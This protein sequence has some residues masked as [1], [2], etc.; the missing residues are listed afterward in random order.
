MKEVFLCRFCLKGFVP[1]LIL[2][3][4]SCSAV[5]RHYWVT[6]VFISNVLQ[7]SFVVLLFSL[8]S[9]NYQFWLAVWKS[10]RVQS[11]SSLV[12]CYICFALNK[13][14][15]SK[16]AEKVAECPSWYCY[17]WILIYRVYIWWLFPSWSSYIPAMQGHSSHSPGCIMT[18]RLYVFI[19]E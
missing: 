19:Y 9:V 2:N 7:N 16:P 18:N 12:R 1:F 3:N 13:Y 11:C 5:L 10:E 8:S 15:W 17:I 6:T 4:F 14:V